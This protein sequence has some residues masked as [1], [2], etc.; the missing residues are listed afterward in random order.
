VIRCKG[1]RVTSRLLASCLSPSRS[2]ETSFPTSGP[3]LA[4]CLRPLKE[5]LEEPEKRLIIQA[6]R[7]MNGN[8]GETARVLDINR[9]TLYN[10][11]IKYGLLLDEPIWVN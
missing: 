10:K 2:T 7:A 11:M 1:T 8:R 9:S 3:P 4:I 6:L 5:A